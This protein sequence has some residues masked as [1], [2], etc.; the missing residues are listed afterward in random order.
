M[1]SVNQSPEFLK[2]LKKNIIRLIVCILFPTTLPAVLFSQRPAQF[3]RMGEEAEATGKIAEAFSLY[4][5]AYE[6]DTTNFEA[7]LHYAKGAL[8]SKDYLLAEKLFT[9]V[10][11]KDSGKL[12][13]EGLFWVAMM[14]KHNGHYEEAMRNFK[15]YAKKHKKKGEYTYEKSL[16]EIESCTWA[17]NYKSVSDSLIFHP[18]EENVNTAESENAAFLFGDRFYFS[19]YRNDGEREAWSMMSATWDGSAAKDPA[20]I[21]IPNLGDNMANLSFGQNDE[22]YFTYCPKNGLCSIWKAML[23]EGSLFS[24]EQVAGLNAPSANTTMPCFTVIQGFSYLFF[25]SDRAGGEGGM[26]IWYSREKNGEWSEPINAG[27]TINSRD[28]EL[29]PFYSTG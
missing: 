19:T 13:S 22:V 11:S 8:L 24:A 20:V 26:D 21:N 16:R 3:I 7:T 23:K 4:E 28:D 29:T 18:L 27:N 25:S 9:K 2:S 6:L 15:K 14:Q 12:F 5:Q 10:Y 17:I 1:K